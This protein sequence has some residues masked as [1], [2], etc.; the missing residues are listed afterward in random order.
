M[1][2]KKKELED[3]EFDGWDQLEVLAVW[4][5]AEFCSQKLGIS[6]DSLD[7][8]LRERYGHG[9]AEYKHKI[10]EPLRI[11][12]MKK[13]YD[14]AMSGN[15]ALLIWLGKQYLK[16]SDKV[17]TKMVEVSKE[18]TKILIKEAQELVE[19]MQ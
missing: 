2:R 16:Q 13:Q 18:D 6:P 4:G 8:R 7:R 15:T 3:M 12:L 19:K 9:F 1:P 14:V 17:E 5:S 11:N 10:Q